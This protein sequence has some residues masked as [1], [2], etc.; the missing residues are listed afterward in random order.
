MEHEPYGLSVADVDEMALLGE[1]TPTDWE[2][3]MLSLLV[4]LAIGWTAIQGY[5]RNAESLTWGLGWGALGYLF[6]VPAVAFTAY[7]QARA[8]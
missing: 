1:E 8:A 4:A 2:S 7:S 6:P 5:E 3:V